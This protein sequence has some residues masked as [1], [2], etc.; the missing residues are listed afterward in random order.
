[1]WVIVEIGKKQ[2]KVQEGD[3]VKVSG[4]SKGKGFQ[5]AVKRWGFAGRGASHGVKHEARTL[6]STGSSFPERV[7]KGRKMPGR[8]GFERTTVKNLK[9]VKIVY[10]WGDSLPVL[11]TKTYSAVEVSLFY[12]LIILTILF[13]LFISFEL[14][15]SIKPYIISII[16]IIYP[17]IILSNSMTRK[18]SG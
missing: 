9:I 7:I 16:P 8:M 17:I 18:Q 6:G 5:G 12:Q 3:V 15:K 10:Y 1:M 2:Y 11:T 13:T 14:L 4:V